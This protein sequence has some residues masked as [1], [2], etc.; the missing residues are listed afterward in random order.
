MKNFPSALSFAAK[1]CVVG[2]GQLENL[3]IEIVHHYSN[4]RLSGIF[5]SALSNFSRWCNGHYLSPTVA[6]LPSGATTYIYH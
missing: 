1:F 4:Q 6:L 5:H 3:L 2:K